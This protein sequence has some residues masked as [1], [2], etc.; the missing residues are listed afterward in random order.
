[1]MQ[2][3]SA[4]KL[5]NLDR[6]ALTRMARR[7]I[8]AIG[9]A[10]GISGTGSWLP[11]EHAVWA[12]DAAKPT[13]SRASSSEAPGGLRLATDTP[14]EVR[15]LKLFL[16]GV[17][18]PP[19]EAAQGIQLRAVMNLGR[20][21]TEA[22]RAEF[23]RS[24][25][26]EINPKSGVVLGG[27]DLTDYTGALA[28]M[29]E[30]SHLPPKQQRQVLRAIVDGIRAVTGKGTEAEQMFWMQAARGDAAAGITIARSVDTWLSDEP[31]RTK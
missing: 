2:L 15:A 24:T 29:Q 21:M 6:A 11:S 31:P 9:V 27:L 17:A 3:L 7:A 18:Y 19:S 26:R 14:A 22:E 30:S 16:A 12:G 8:C 13:N 23:R 10:V 25:D 1:M 5:A 20:Q 28:A 4:R